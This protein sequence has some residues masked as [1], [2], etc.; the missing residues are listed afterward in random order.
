[1]QLY[2]SLT[3]REDWT[4]I[5]F[6]VTEKDTRQLHVN[7]TLTMHLRNFHAFQGWTGDVKVSHSENSL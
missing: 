3:T 4:G 1:M 6:K 2:M 7:F 5:S